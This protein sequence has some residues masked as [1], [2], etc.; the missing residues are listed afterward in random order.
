MTASDD[1]LVTEKPYADLSPKWRL[2]FEFFDAHGAPPMWKFDR[3][4]GEATKAL[5][6]RDRMRLT[7]NGY[8]FFFGVFYLLYLGMWR[9]ALT[10]VGVLV[11]LT[12]VEIA[13]D[14]PLEI[15]TA[16]GFGVGAYLSAR[17]NI[18]YY[19]HRVHGERGWGL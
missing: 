9:K 16:I 18:L 4:Y 15:D 1:R 13:L 5:S 19:R 3:E 7:T 10:V 2:R 6:I 12:A 8:A 11:V 17:V 14:L